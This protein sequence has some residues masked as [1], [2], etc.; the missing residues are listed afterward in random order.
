MDVIGV[1][2]IAVV[3]LFV[4]FNGFDWPLPLPLPL[5]PGRRAAGAAS[6]GKPMERVTAPSCFDGPSLAAAAAARERRGEEGRRRGR[7][8]AVGRG[9][10][11]EGRRGF[12]QRD[13]NPEVVRR[14]RIEGEENEEEE[15]EE[16]EEGEGEEDEE[17]KDAQRAGSRIHTPLGSAYRY[18]FP[19]YYAAEAYVQY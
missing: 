8:A 17:E 2:M 13:G 19:Y 12:G 4:D 14:W 10:I 3:G 1:C 5:S 7:R 11:G 18:V 9:G 16:E 6:R 15:E